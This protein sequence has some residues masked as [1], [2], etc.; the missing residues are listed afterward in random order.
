MKGRKGAMKAMRERRARATKTVAYETDAARCQAV[1]AQGTVDPGGAAPDC[2]GRRESYLTRPAHARSRYMLVNP[3]RNGVFPPESRTSPADTW[4]SCA[5]TLPAR[6]QHHQT[7]SHRSKP[8]AEDAATYPE[9]PVTSSR[10]PATITA[11]RTPARAESRR[12]AAPPLPFDAPG[13]PMPRIAQMAAQA[14]R[15]EAVDAKSTD[16]GLSAV[17]GRRVTTRHR[18][19]E[20]RHEDRVEPEIPRKSCRKKPRKTTQAQAKLRCVGRIRRSPRSMRR[21]P[22]EEKAASPG[23]REPSS[24]RTGNGAFARASTRKKP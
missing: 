13:R 15:P 1:A 21:R 20:R 14:G 23:V 12:E 17:S 24:R 6:S 7:D 9:T 4:R 8:S 5:S 18:H 3:D 22:K 10:A 16:K 11:A 19:M 2:S